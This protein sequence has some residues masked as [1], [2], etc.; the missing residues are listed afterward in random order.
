MIGRTPRRSSSLNALGVRFTAPPITPGL[1]RISKTRIFGGADAGENLARAMAAVR[2]RNCCKH[3]T[4]IES[5]TKHDDRPATP[6]PRIK[7]SRGVSLLR[8]MFDVGCKERAMRTSWL[9]VYKAH[10]CVVS[11]TQGGSIAPACRSR[12][13]LR[14]VWLK[15]TLF[16]RTR[17]PS[18]SSQLTTSG[19]LVA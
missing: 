8:D 2:P 10:C 16:T 3:H 18:L 7:I 4:T 19:V 1:G 17:L 15:V 12:E 6:P 14:H 5:H 13:Y 11:T 9:L